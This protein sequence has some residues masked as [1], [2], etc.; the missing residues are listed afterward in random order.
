[1][2]TSQAKVLVISAPSGAG[3]TTLVNA[4][5]ERFDGFEFSVSAT[6]RA[7]RAH[8]QDG[9]EYYFISIAE[10]TRL[11]EEDAFLEWEEVYPG[12]CYGTLKSEVT[13][14]LNEDKWPIFDVDV[15]G[16]LNIKHHY[17][18]R[19]L[20]LYIQPPSLEVL[21][22]RLTRRGTDSPEDIERRVR[23]AEY[24][25]TFASQFDHI[26][27]NDDLEKAIAQLVDL[28]SKRLSPVP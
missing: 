18:A 2:H 28:I 26:I 15:K 4:M 14:I 7:P 10:F 11:R 6:T 12:K 19:A 16:G 17:G 23:K 21:R 22:E 3:K 24:E 1:M 25:M 13:R 27:I 5:L 8:E 9:R 20:A